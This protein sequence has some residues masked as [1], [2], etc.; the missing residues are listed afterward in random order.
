MKTDVVTVQVQP[1]NSFKGTLIFQMLSHINNWG[2][3]LWKFDLEAE[4]CN[5]AAMSIAL[6]YLPA[7]GSG[8]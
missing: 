6:T 4:L 7:T 3:A 5:N 2:K 1:G 8:H